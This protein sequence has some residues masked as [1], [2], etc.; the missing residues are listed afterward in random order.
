MFEDLAFPVYLKLHTHSC[1]GRFSHIKDE[2]VALLVDDE[3]PQGELA[4]QLGHE[5]P[6]LFGHGPNAS[7]RQPVSHL[8]G[9]TFRLNNLDVEI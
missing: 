3:S 6:D 4:H 1:P 5:R 9:G 8:D 2:S 7:G